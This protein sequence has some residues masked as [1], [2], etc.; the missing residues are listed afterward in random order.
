MSIDQI[1]DNIYAVTLLGWP[2]VV[3]PTDVH[4]SPTS[5]SKILYFS[6]LIVALPIDMANFDNSNLLNSAESNSAPSKLESIEAVSFPGVETIHDSTTLSGRYW[7]T[8]DR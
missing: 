1:L 3:T 4:N 7:G 2:D 8:T 6:L 5:A